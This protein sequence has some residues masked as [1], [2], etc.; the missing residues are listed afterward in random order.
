MNLGR[1]LGVFALRLLKPIG[2]PTILLTLAALLGIAS[3]TRWPGNLPT[4]SLHDERWAM[5]ILVSKIAIERWKALDTQDRIF[6]ASIGLAWIAMIWFAF[7]ELL[8]LGVIVARRPH[9]DQKPLG[10]KARLFVAASL[11]VAI[12]LIGYGWPYRMARRAAEEVLN[13]APSTGPVSVAW[14]GAPLPFSISNDDLQVLRTAV[15]C[16]PTRRQRIAGISR[17]V[18]CDPKAVLSVLIDAVQQEKDPVVVAA[19]LHLI[20]LHRDAATAKRLATFLDARDPTIRAAA[21]DALGYLLAPAFEVR[22]EILS[23]SPALATDPP[24]PLAP[25]FP[26]LLHPSVSS[27]WPPGEV[28]PLNSIDILDDLVTCLRPMMVGAPTTEE[29]EAVARAMLRWPPVNYHLRLAE[30]GVWIDSGGKLQLVQSVI[31]EIPPFVHRTGNPVSSFA[32]RINQIMFVTKPII[33]LTSSQPIA[34]DLQVLIK[35]G[36]PWFAYPRPDDF[37]VD[38]QSIQIQMRQNPNTGQW[39]SLDDGDPLKPLDP[40]ALPS[41]EDLREGHPWIAPSHQRIGPF[42]GQGN[43]VNKITSLGLRWQSL[44]VSPE[45]LPW[46][47]PPPVPSD[48]KYQWWSRLREV[49]CSWV[50]SRG[51][52]ERFVYYDGPTLEPSPWTITEKGVLQAGSSMKDPPEGLYI[53]VKEGHVAGI[54]IPVTV[55]KTIPVK[56]PLPLHDDEVEAHLKSILKTMK[57]TDA[58]ADGLIACWRQQFFK[59]NGRRFLTIFHGADYDRLCPL[60]IRPEPTEKVRVGILLREIGP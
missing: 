45:K 21:I 58:E 35:N 43:P 50:A 27:R 39:K 57:L 18:Q 41:A 4:F 15:R 6:T 40:A 8:R 47:Q 59:T 37:A 52:A 30:W 19:E 2:W 7:R 33:H 56:G 17:L 5:R 42:G 13:P 23:A 24:V 16:L 11:L 12:L 34:V 54:Q 26:L 49:P 9:R 53:E 3:L 31:D 25:L 55:F 32:D 48:P 1:P 14:G 44:I 29:R 38:V 20:G 10:K 46:M 22:G 60:T 28:L 51:E 36:R